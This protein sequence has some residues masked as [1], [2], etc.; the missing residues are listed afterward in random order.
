MNYPP[1]TFAGRLIV[2]VGLI[3]WVFLLA[4]CGRPSVDV[5]P[6]ATEPVDTEAPPTNL[7][8]TVFQGISL[9]VADQGPCDSTGA[10]VSGF[11]RN[12]VG[13]SLAAINATVRMSIAPDGEWTL[14]GQQMLAPGLGRDQWA[15]ARSQISITKPITA[16]APRIAGYHV[17]AY[18]PDR[19]E[20]AIFT[21]QSDRSLTRNAA[22][23]IWRVG[24]WKLLLPNQSRS[25]PVETVT[26]LPANIVP[27]QL[28]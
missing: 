27:L 22:T 16:N 14:I 7:K 4:G 24:D 18:T 26:A 8:T 10:V 12:P 1:S 13:A 5:T 25:S 15:T 20:V 21:I 23:V 17:V 28:P 19:A 3:G 11:D 6:G 9:P 2:G